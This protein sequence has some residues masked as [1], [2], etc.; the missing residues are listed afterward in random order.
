MYYDDHLGLSHNLP[1][2]SY[3][4]HSIIQVI[5]HSMLIYIIFCLVYH[6][7]AGHEK[8]DGRFQALL[9]LFSNTWMAILRHASVVYCLYKILSPRVISMLALRRSI[10]HP[11]WTD[12]ILPSNI[13]FI[14][15]KESREKD[16]G[17][18]NITK[19]KKKYRTFFRL[20]S[21]T[22]DSMKWSFPWEFFGSWF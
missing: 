13:Y 15:S 1:C 17:S 8:S 18:I 22:N 2:G 14:S 20:H 6:L 19:L 7:M 10:W 21:H 9:C 11:G 3:F 12:K 16:I 5:F 4:F